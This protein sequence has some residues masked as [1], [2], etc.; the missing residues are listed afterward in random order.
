MAASP[1][2]SDVRARPEV[3]IM[4]RTLADFMNTL[5]ESGGR[6]PHKY[7]CWGLVRAVRHEYFGLPL[8]ASWGDV[9]ADD[10]RRL[11]AACLHEA[12]RFTPGPPEPASIATVWRGQLC[13]HVAI[14]FE[15]N[16]RLAVLETGR[17]IGTRWAYLPDFEAQYLKVVY[18]S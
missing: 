11:T 14:V 2:L 15:N 12:Q 8:L 1:L 4:S 18:Y 5:Y 10:K 17:K 9:H 3:S 7:D 6:G 13:I 16:G